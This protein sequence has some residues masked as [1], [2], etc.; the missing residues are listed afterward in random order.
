MQVPPFPSAR[1]ASPRRASSCWRMKWFVARVYWIGSEWP[2]IRTGW[3]PQLLVS[4]REHRST[5][6]SIHLTSFLSA[7]WMP[8]FVRGPIRLWFL[9]VS[10]A[11]VDLCMLPNPAEISWCNSPNQENF[12]LL[13]P[14]LAPGMLWWPSKSLP[15]A[16]CR[17]P[18]AK[19]NQ[20][21]CYENKFLPIKKYA[22]FLEHS[23]YLVQSFIVLLLCFTIHND[24]AD[25]VQT[26]VATA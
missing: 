10:I 19:K 22:V 3:R 5:P 15:L 2:P 18:M 13:S 25:K 9:S 21:W 12:G 23:Q 7:S 11:A 17:L 14:Y 4:R 1:I 8:V 20:L 6:I 26:V 24:V 16:W